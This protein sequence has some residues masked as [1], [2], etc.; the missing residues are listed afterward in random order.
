MKKL[1]LTMIAV[2]LGMALN[3]Q[4]SVWDGT[5]EPWTMGNGTAE[6]P[7]LIENAQQLAYL[8]EQVNAPSANTGWGY[9]FFS[10]TY[11]LLTT[12]LDLGGANDLLWNPIGKNDLLHGALTY[13]CGHF[14]GGNHT[15][16]NMHVVSQGDRSNI[17][18]GLFGS[19]K[20][21]SIK[22]IALASNCNVDIN[23][24]SLG[25]EMETSLMIGGV[26]GQGSNV[27]LE[28][29]VSWA[30]VTTSVERIYN[31]IEC[32]GLFGV[33]N[34]NSSV[35]N[36]HNKGNVNCQGSV[37]HGNLATAGIVGGTGGC[38]LYGCTNSGNVTMV[39]IDWGND[40]GCVASGGI[41]GVTRGDCNVEMCSNTG[42]ILVN[43]ELCHYD[44][45]VSSGG[46][47]GCSWTW[48]NSTN[49]NIKN[50][51]SVAN[52]SAITNSN[53]D[54]GNYAGGIFGATYGWEAEG[55]SNQMTIENC[56][57]VGDFVADSIG[58]ILAIY[59]TV[60]YDKSSDVLNSY[61]I[62]TIESWNGYGVSL[63]D[64]EMKTQA[65]VDMLN[66]EEIVFAMDENN[67]NNGFPVFVIRNLCGVEDIATSN[68]IL[69]Y[70]NPANNIINIGISDN[71]RCDA[72]YI[73]SI[74]GK[75]VRSVY[76]NVNTI[77]ITDLNS[78]I[79]IMKV[80]TSDGTDIT[81]RVVIK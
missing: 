19:A 38:D 10:D 3:A 81:Q 57:A 11:F 74:D 27:I 30:S 33:L 47:V 77:N 36:C 6:D 23:F 62:N 21:G 29:C 45:P 18:F 40:M 78:G 72:V 32:G 76:D 48:P 28:N 69:I 41:V 43:E 51:Y 17:D 61:Y 24:D 52:I 60:G 15:I 4:V 58:G 67:E 25:G 14:D 44:F 73:Y 34:M 55:V 22:N 46:I 64:E 42:I 8:A 50:C 13:F 68:E 37:Y 26:L 12:D 20:N 65:F 1:V 59:G 31:S 16:Y 54:K 63:S 49:L 79:Y 35:R 39:K 80:K 2:L 9:E 53:D 5:A 71:A 66:T 56:Y 7:Y 75:L 70:P